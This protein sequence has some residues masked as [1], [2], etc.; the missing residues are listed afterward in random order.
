MGGFHTGNLPGYLPATIGLEDPE[1]EIV[2]G[3]GRLFPFAALLHKGLA[4]HP[5]ETLLYRAT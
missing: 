5:F 4:F 3:S 1:Y 2:D